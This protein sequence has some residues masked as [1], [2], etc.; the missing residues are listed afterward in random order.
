MGLWEWGVFHN[1]FMHLW[2]FFLTDS[3]TNII[4]Y[5]VVYKVK[6]LMW[7]WTDLW[8]LPYLIVDFFRVDNYLKNCSTN[9]SWLL[10]NIT[11]GNIFSDPLIF[12]QV[13]KK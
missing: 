3:T 1:F 7:L 2:L 12:L 13:V 4:L 11:S 9:S 5:V 8:E 10:N 6:V